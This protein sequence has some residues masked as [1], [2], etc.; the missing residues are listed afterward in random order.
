MQDA[1]MIYFNGEKNAGLFLT[2]LGIICLATAALF[3]QARWEMRSFAV[4]LAII[5]LV[6]LAIGLGLYL[7]TGSQAIGLLAQLGTDAAGFLPGRG[8]MARVQRNFVVIQYVELAVIVIAAVVAVSQ[9]S[10]FWVSGIAL[11]FLVHASLLLAFDLVAERR[12][13]RYLAL[14]REEARSA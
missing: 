1:L 5:A 14:V 3:Y 6:E 13:A 8:R 9:K 12:G 4:T 7:R 11:A 10:R 2:A